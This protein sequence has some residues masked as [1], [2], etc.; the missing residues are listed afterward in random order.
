MF[1]KSTK[2]LPKRDQEAVEREDFGPV[3]LDAC[4][5]SFRQGGSE[6]IAREA[7]LLSL[8]WGLSLRILRWEGEK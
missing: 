1:L 7:H 6:G 2:S 4:R 8:D 5:E 3:M